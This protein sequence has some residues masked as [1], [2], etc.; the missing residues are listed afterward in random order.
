MDE[1]QQSDSQ[2]ASVRS[3]AYENAKAEY[4]DR[5]RTVFRGY[6]QRSIGFADVQSGHAVLDV[7]CG[8]GEDV[9]ALGGIVGSGGRAVGVDA[10]PRMI[11][12]A[13][14]RACERALPVEFVEADGTS[15]PFDDETFDRT[16][17]DRVFQYLQPPEKAL[18]EM[19]RVT[20]RGGL[21][22]SF[23]ADWETLVVDSAYPEL[24]RRIFNCICERHPQGR[25]GRRLY[26]LF[27][28]AGL[29]G[30]E[31]VSE[32]IC[33]TDAAMAV[34][35]WGLDNFAL[36]AAESGAVT[37]DEADSWLQDL[38]ARGARDSFFGSFTGFGVRG[39]KT[40]PTEA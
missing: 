14:A 20:R 5:V 25:I 3:R 21:V 8:T 27:R 1:Q 17:S 30:V 7:G 39:R 15:L 10:D 4:L 23:D 13:K 28:E 18:A 22:S 2:A 19:L 12:V 36:K 24:T 32:S 38:Q 40:Q 35:L 9:L 11:Q 34:P 31:V 16:R 33:I 29:D 37:R 6:K 26:G